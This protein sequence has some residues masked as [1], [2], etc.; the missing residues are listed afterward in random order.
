MFRSIRCVLPSEIY[1]RF[2]SIATNLALL[3]LTKVWKNDDTHFSE[4][5]EREKEFQKILNFA[6]VM[7]VR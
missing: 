5:R 2:A 6:D 4:E 3:L 1:G 7:T